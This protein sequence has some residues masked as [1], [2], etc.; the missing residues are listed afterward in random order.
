MKKELQINF[1]HQKNFSVEKKNLKLFHIPGKAIPF[2][3]GT[4][5]MEILGLLDLRPPVFE[6]LC[7]LKQ[8]YKH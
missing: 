2:P 7:N 8:I 3:P 1:Y 5:V 6:M 4:G